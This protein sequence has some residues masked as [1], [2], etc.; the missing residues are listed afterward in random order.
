[1]KRGW[2]KKVK[3]VPNAASNNALEGRCK[4]VQPKIKRRVRTSVAMIGLVI[5]MG[6]P[7]L[8]LTRESDR[9]PA[10]EPVGE[11]T[12]STI[13]P[14]TESLESS[15][16]LTQEV[17][18]VNPD[19]LPVA[20]PSKQVEV[21]A[22]DKQSGLLEAQV[23][24]AAPQPVIVQKAPQVDSGRSREY[25]VEKANTEVRSIRAK[26]QKLA[27]VTDKSVSNITPPKAI[28]SEP[29]LIAP[30]KS[31]IIQQ[32]APV[33]QNDRA[34]R[35]VQRLKAQESVTLAKSSEVKN[36]QSTA[37][38]LGDESLISNSEV[39][40]AV[41]VKQRLLINRLK[42]SSR[43]QDN[44]TEIKSQS[45][46]FTEFTQP[47]FTPL[48]VQNSIKASAGSG[49]IVE[50]KEE[51]AAA[52]SPVA[53]SNNNTGFGRQQSA[54]I[55]A[56]EVGIPALNTAMI[57]PQQVANPRENLN[58]R[59]PLVTSQQ[60]IEINAASSAPDAPI[61]AP[62]QVVGSPTEDLQPAEIDAAVETLP[63]NV[64]IIA[65]PQ[66]AGSPA[67]DLQ[68][69]EIDTAAVETLPPN[70][71]I[72]APQQ[73]VGSSS[74]ENS[75]QTSSSATSDEL[76]LEAQTQPNSDVFVVPDVSAV[77]ATQAEARSQAY[78]VKSG[79]TLSAIARTHKIPLL[80]L[81][82]VNQLSNPD[83]L[84]INQ[85][86][87][88]PTLQPSSITGQTITVI[89]RPDQ[90]NKTST[91]ASAFSSQT[92]FVVP[93]SSDQPTS[94]STLP[95]STDIQT[96]TQLLS[97]NSLKSQ[98]EGLAV[99]P[100]ESPDLSSSDYSGM[101]GSISDEAEELTDPALA[102]STT[103]TEPQSNSSVEN[104]Q[105]DIQKLRQKYYVQ[106]ADSQLVSR[107]SETKKVA[108]SVAVY[109]PPSKVIM[110]SRGTNPRPN[111]PINPEFRV[112]QAAVLQ[113]NYKQAST[114]PN[115]VVAPKTKA[116]VATAPNSVDTSTMG[117]F[118][119]R[120]VSPEL[121]PLGGVDTY[122]PKPTSTSAKGYIWPAKGVLTSGYGWRWGRMHKGIDV[123]APIGTPVVAASQGVV[124]R[125]GWNSGGYGNLVIIKHT[126]GTL[127][128]YAHNNRVLVQAGQQVE[129]G[130]L[131]A[132]MGST[133]FSTGSHVHFEVH[134]GGKGA[135]NPIAFL[136][137]R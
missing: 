83:L 75:T 111:E 18:A 40:S 36:T 118:R 54:E 98:P 80:E 96:N 117:A 7:N 97:S 71:P 62:Q 86:I 2:T 105:T 68:P 82:K 3:A 103:A 100:G 135:V 57:A 16:V 89:N 9:A 129:Q 91:V 20:P 78:Q 47:R 64:P 4:R 93:P 88:I 114:Q 110:R 34:A 53:T 23:S 25:Q 104:L 126:D 55:N 35:L 50:T 130:Q 58:L 12:I 109:S 116:S 61:I 92:V 125:S 38:P 84:E 137:G 13:P 60:E 112:A 124:V 14:T 5:S 73:V 69:A 46:T 51:Q 56:G 19:Q 102:N 32:A 66:V 127:T 1:M 128:R 76:V 8:L 136:P 99:P 59:S 134:P 108:T 22:T 28:A 33:I 94:V 132:E 79:D 37:S 81:V 67:E 107:V 10:A 17:V 27:E 52:R 87:K 11:P 115:A 43:P 120:Q 95:V 106:S 133:G 119:G 122:L 41:S 49:V 113:P 121:P 77:N 42:Q 63:P 131:I 29:E 101:G 44:S 6:A 123:A 70:V 26:Y 30:A 24:E 21:K 15:A 45:S 72:V 39:N 65:P 48:R 31:N 85:Q 74:P 90:P